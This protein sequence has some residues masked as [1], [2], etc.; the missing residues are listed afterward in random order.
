MSSSRTMGDLSDGG[1]PDLPDDRVQ[2]WAAS[3]TVPDGALARLEQC[4]SEDEHQRAATY[5]R[6]EHIRRFILARA[7]LREV[8]AAYRKVGAHEVL[9]R[10]ETNGKPLLAGG[11]F[12][13]NLSHS[14]DIACVAVTRGR[15]VGI[16]VEVIRENRDFLDIARRFFA[17][18]EAARV[19]QVHGAERARE[20]FAYWTCKEAY[21]KG[22][23]EG[24]LSPLDKVKL[25][26]DGTGDEVNVTDPRGAGPWTLRQLRL[27][28]GLAAAI[29]V[30]GG[31][32]VLSTGWWSLD[33]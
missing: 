19:E 30:E 29:A 32:S 20:F 27:R 12:E 16:D 8:L 14:E 21:L 18:S 13:F 11:D 33:R 24:L 4:L 15:R 5:Y 23:G 2:V 28:D 6:P 9:F 25:T 17:P 3:L 7:F 22:R 31:G 1:R 10:Y 26:F